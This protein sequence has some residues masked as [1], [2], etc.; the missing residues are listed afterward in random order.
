[1]TSRSDLVALLRRLAPN[2]EATFRRYGVTPEEAAVVLDEAVLEVQLR[3]S[4][5]PDCEGR[6][7]RAVER[8]CE[9]RVRRRRCAAEGRREDVGTELEDD[10]TAP[11]T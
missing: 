1:M 7:L 8:G 10:E 5:T 3:A 9:E 11:E 6:L 2:L 4:R